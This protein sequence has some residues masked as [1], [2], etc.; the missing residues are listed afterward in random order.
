MFKWTIFEIEQVGA[1]LNSNGTASIKKVWLLVHAEPYDHM[2]EESIEQAFQKC[3][4][5][6][7]TAKKESK[8]VIQEIYHA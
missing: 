4:E 3:L 7:K 1:I 8:Y 2:D 5:W 6:L